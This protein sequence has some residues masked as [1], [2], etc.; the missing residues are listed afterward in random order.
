MVL[1]REYALVSDEYEPEEDA[2]A[3]GM[4]LERGSWLNDL[5]QVPREKEHSFED[6]S[7]V[8]LLFD[9]VDI[10]DVA[11]ELAAESDDSL[12]KW[13][14]NLSLSFQHTDFQALLVECN[15]RRLQAHQQTKEF[16]DNAH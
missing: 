8:K 4:F 5:P 10:E 3:F 12:Q 9:Y 13:L 16:L 1:R 2:R 14:L 6:P 7:I 15:A 11:P